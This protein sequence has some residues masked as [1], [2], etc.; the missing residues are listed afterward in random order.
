[1]L[2]LSILANVFMIWACFKCHSFRLW[3][4]GDYAVV[5]MLLDNFHLK[6][7]YTYIHNF[8]LFL[9]CISFILTNCVNEEN[10]YMFSYVFQ[11]LCTFRAIKLFKCQTNNT[12]GMQN[13]QYSKE[14][15][16]H[17][18]LSVFNTTYTIQSR[19]NCSIIIKIAY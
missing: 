19:V 5:C 18:Q 12:F 15:S 11:K 8:H 17:K 7:R 14:L 13:T 1:M 2:S 16:V 9:K 3:L 10:F 4:L 6:I